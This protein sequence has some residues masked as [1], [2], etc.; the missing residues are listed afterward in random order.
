MDLA[1]GKYAISIIHDE[2]NNDKL[3]TNFIG[4]PKEGFGFS[5]NPRIMFGPPSFEKASFE[6][7]QA[8]VILIEMK[9]F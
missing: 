9:Y 6:I 1:P 3:D 7:N 8:H 2:N 5:N 4:I